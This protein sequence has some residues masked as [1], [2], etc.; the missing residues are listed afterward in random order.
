MKGGRV[1]FNRILVCLMGLILVIFGYL[2][3]S[4]FEKKMFTDVM[5]EDDID[6]ERIT[7]IVIQTRVETIGDPLVAEIEDP[8]LIDQIMQD[9]SAIEVRQQPTK[10]PRSLDH[11]LII[12][13]Y[14]SNHY[15]SF[16]K[17][18]LV[19]GGMDHRVLEGSFVDII[20]NLGSDVEWK[21]WE[22]RFEEE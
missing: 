20:R 17:E 2:L 15:F 7:G 11:T 16:D 1:L 19:A 4:S 13:A 8:A 10:S 5:E 3:L 21:T 18:Y 9:L 6:L 12:D 22:E 14:F